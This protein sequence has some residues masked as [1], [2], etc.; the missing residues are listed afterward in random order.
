MDTLIARTETL[1]D[2]SI[3]RTV[4]AKLKEVASPL[5]FGALCDGVTDDAVALQATF[6]SAARIIDAQGLRC[7]TNSVLTLPASKI[8]RNIYLDFSGVTVIGVPSTTYLTLETGF[9]GTAIALTADLP[10]PQWRVSLTNSSL[11]AVGDYVQFQSSGLFSAGNTLGEMAVVNWISNDTVT[12]DVAEGV[13]LTYLTSDS[14]T[15][16]KLNFNTGSELRNVA[17]LG[18][19]TNLTTESVIGV[20]ITLA[21]DVLIDHVNVTDIYTTGIQITTSWNVI[22]QNSDLQNMTQDG[23]AYGV[24]IVHCCCFVKVLNS[25][26][27]NM[28]HGATT[29]GTDGVNYAIEYIGNTV[30]GTRDAGLDMHPSTY[31]GTILGNTISVSKGIPPSGQSDGIVFQG[32]NGVIADNNIYGPT[33]NTVTATRTAIYYQSLCINANVQQ[34]SAIITEN[35]I[36]APVTGIHLSLAGSGGRLLQTASI[37]GNTITGFTDQGILVH[38]SLQSLGGL[39][40]AANSLRTT[41]AISTSAAI[42]VRSAISREIEDVSIVANTISGTNTSVLRGIQIICDVSSTGIRELAITANTVYLALIGINFSGASTI[43]VASLSGNVFNAATRVAYV[44]S[45]LPASQRVGFT[46]TLSNDANQ[47]L[48]LGS[49]T[50]LSTSATIGYV[51]ITSCAGPPTGVPAGAAAGIIPIHYDTSNSIPYWYSSGWK[52]VVSSLSGTA[53]QITASASTGGV[54]LSIPSVFVGPGS[55]IATTILE[56][57]T[58]TRVGTNILG[59]GTEPTWTLGAGAHCGSTATGNLGGSNQWMI[60]SVTTGTGPCPGAATVVELDFGVQTGISTSHFCTVT[61]QNGYAGDDGF[62][63]A[64]TSTIWVLGSPTAGLQPN[65][66]YQ[67][68]IGPCGGV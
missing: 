6:N 16:R 14:A 56:S 44:S 62:T 5:D 29:G 15:L 7:K 18:S 2:F 21:K 39:S 48:S 43:S 67:W 32:V 40:I 42:Q 52:T 3:Y 46:G 58:E 57:T 30:Y 10:T 28:R 20:R 50:A 53:N 11:F 9:A 4:E 45:V 19:L 59:T 26:F 61:P 49:G 8:L 64:G 65:Q 33:P 25:H 54:T 38:A 24:S 51:G 12:L 36:T 37:V 17:I 47:V 63:S 13:H 31:M 35:V 34:Y 27:T 60:F 23:L 1:T 22:V 41:N 68:V 55:V 66:G